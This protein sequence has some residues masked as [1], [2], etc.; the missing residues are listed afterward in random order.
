MR[1]ERPQIIIGGIASRA[2]PQQGQTTPV[3][4]AVEPGR[5]SHRNH[6]LL[7]DLQAA[8]LHRHCNQRQHL[9]GV[10]VIERQSDHRH[11]DRVLTALECRLHVRRKKIGPPNGGAVGPVK[12]ATGFRCFSVIHGQTLGHAR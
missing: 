4:S 9:R 3:H 12:I 6:A 5:V 8:G 1:H 2:R 10:R 7:T 11:P